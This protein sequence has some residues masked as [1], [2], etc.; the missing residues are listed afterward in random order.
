MASSESKIRKDLAASCVRQF[1][2]LATYFVLTI[3]LLSVHI[4]AAISVG[5]V[6]LKPSTGRR[7]LVRLAF[8][9]SAHANFFV[10]IRL[11]LQKLFMMYQCL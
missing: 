4:G 2:T 7:V 10:S 5:E 8:P 3:G 6:G 1:F 11:S 9:V